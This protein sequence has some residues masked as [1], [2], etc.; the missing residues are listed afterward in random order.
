MGEVEF[1]ACGFRT[2]VRIIVALGEN[3]I[4]VQLDE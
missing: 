1:G 2:A 3:K 4:L